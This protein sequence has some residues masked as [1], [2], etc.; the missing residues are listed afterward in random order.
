MSWFSGF[1]AVLF[2]LD[3]TLVDSAP[4]LAAAINKVKRD[5]GES[6]V[7]YE[8]LRAVVS[9][10][11]RAMLSVAFPDRS[12]EQRESLLKPFLDY[13]ARSLAELSAPFEQVSELLAQ[14]EQR[15]IIWGVVTNKPEYLAVDV[16]RGMQWQQRCA[17]LIGGDTLPQKKPEP[18][19]LLVAAQRIGIDPQRC[20]YVGDDL[21]DIQAARAAGMYSVA[22]HWGYREADENPFD[23]NA[24]LDL[25]S[26][27]HTF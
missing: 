23:W 22:A 3:G 19:P 6:D 7:A 5:Q 12:M 2:D 8:A 24:D 21:R 18:E 26:A 9:K 25:R 15:N 27:L 17:V 13:Y 14:L 4:D 20:A 10:G 11:G 16:I 1:E